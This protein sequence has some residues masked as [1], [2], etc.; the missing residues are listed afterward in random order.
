M[1][2]RLARSKIMEAEDYFSISIKADEDICPHL[3]SF[4]LLKTIDA[5]LHRKSNLLDIHGD[6]RQRRG[7]SFLDLDIL[8]NGLALEQGEGPGNGPVEILRADI[9]M[10]LASELPHLVIY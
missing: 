8:E 5:R 6:L 7:K 2:I 10:S 9:L 3:A 1:Q 4:G